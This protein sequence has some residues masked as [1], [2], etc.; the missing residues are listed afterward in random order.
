MH[1]VDAREGREGADST[2]DDL[3]ALRPVDAAFAFLELF[4]V[5]DPFLWLGRPGEVVGVFERL[6][7]EIRADVRDPV[8]E[9]RVRILLRDRGRAHGDHGAGIESE[10]H[11][12]EGDARLGV[13]RLDGAGDRRR[14][15]PAGQKAAVNVDRAVPTDAFGAFEHGRGKNEPVGHHD[16]HVGLEIA[17]RFMHGGRSFGVP[18]EAQRLR[19]EHGQAVL[20]RQGLHGRGR[21][22]HPAAARPIGLREHQ[23]DFVTRADQGFESHRGKVR[24][25]GKNQTHSDSK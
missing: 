12:H 13:A 4:R 11:L 5:H 1:E 25:S 20:K 6:D 24:S 18:L 14:P 16:E 8:H 7:Q 19:R 23:C 3:G 21:E 10:L 9:R 22:L 2:G 17:Q 15:A